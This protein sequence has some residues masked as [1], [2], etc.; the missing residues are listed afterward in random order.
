VGASMKKEPIERI[1]LANGLTLQLYNKTRI[2]AGDRYRVVFSARIEFELKP[3]YFSDND[4]NGLSF[5]AV[6]SALGDRVVYTYENVRNFIDEIEKKQTFE[7]LKAHFLKTGMAYLSSPDFPKKLIL[8]KY[9]QTQTY[10]PSWV[11]I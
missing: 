5:G 11:R 3:E 9:R 6:R 8:R 4:R 10:T 7:E 1:E 2:V